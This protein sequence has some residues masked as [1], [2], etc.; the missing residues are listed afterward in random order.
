MTYRLGLNAAFDKEES[1]GGQQSQRFDE[2]NISSKQGKHRS[3]PLS[4]GFHFITHYIMLL[5]VHLCLGVQWNLVLHYDPSMSPCLP[6]RSNITIE[7]L[8]L[9]IQNDG[10]S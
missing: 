1:L 6:L 9:L 2:A 5:C 10:R 4:L 3:I 7:W 8:C